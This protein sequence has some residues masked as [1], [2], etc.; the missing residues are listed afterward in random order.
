MAKYKSTKQVERKKTAMEN[1]KI[2]LDEM[3]QI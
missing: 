1:Q 2:T 3:L